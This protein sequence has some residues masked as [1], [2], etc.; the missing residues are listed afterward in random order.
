MFLWTDMFMIC[1]S[2]YKYST[3]TSSYVFIHLQNKIK[4][5]FYYVFM[6]TWN[7]K[8]LWLPELTYAPSFKGLQVCFNCYSLQTFQ[9]LLLNLTQWPFKVGLINNV[10]LPEKDWIYTGHSWKSHMRVLGGSLPPATLPLSPKK[11]NSLGSRLTQNVFEEPL[12]FW[13]LLIQ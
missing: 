6:M 8:L 11:K 5:V 4:C 3:F 2:L 7:L 12:P 13:R 9:Y 10:F 1:S